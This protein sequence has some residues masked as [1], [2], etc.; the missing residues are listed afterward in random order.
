M[1]NHPTSDTPGPDDSTLSSATPAEKT[2]SPT[3]YPQANV[4]G[5]DG[6][7]L[8]D[9]LANPQ[10]QEIPTDGSSGQP[11]GGGG[12]TLAVFPCEQHKDPETEDAH[13]CCEFIQG[14]LQ[15]LGQMYE[16]IGRVESMVQ[17]LAALRAE[18]AELKGKKRLILP[19]AHGFG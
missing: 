12:F 1:T 10:S 5:V 16:L 4:D 7:T 19:G 3:G 2:T 18:N 9:R 14:Q 6:Q 17:Q 8:S 13:V 11:E 15:Q